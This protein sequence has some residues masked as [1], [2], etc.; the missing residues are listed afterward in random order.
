MKEEK[1]LGKMLKTIYIGN[2]PFN[3]SEERVRDFFV[4]YFLRWHHPRL[5]SFPIIT[6]LHKLKPE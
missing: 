5:R 2:L 6:I 4:T 1:K 3:V